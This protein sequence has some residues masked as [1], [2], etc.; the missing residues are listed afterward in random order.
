MSD[1]SFIRK[2]EQMSM[3]ELLELVLGMPEY[4]TDGYYRHFGN[5]IRERADHL[6]AAVTDDNK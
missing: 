1:A 6:L 5:A 3:P 2:I 4:L